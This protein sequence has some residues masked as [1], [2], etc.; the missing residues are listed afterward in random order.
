MKNL[1]L[2]IIWNNAYPFKEKILEELKTS[3]S[4]LKVT[5]ITWSKEKFNENLNRFYGQKLPKNS[6]KE[7]ACGLGPFTLVIVEDECPQY[8]DRKTTRGQFERVNIHTFDKKMLFREWTRLPSGNNCVHGTNTPE[9]TEHDL[10]LLLGVCPDDFYTNPDIVPSSLNQDIVGANGWKS[11]EQLFYVLNHTSKYVFLRNFEGIPGSFNIA[12][13]DDIDLLVEDYDNFKRIAN[14]F[15]V[16]TKKYRVQCKCLISGE[17]VQFDFRY[18]GDGYYDKCW[19]TNIMDT[20]EFNGHVF[21]PSE[22]NYRYMILY[23]AL[24]QKKTIAD[25]YIALLNKMFGDGQWDL[26]VLLK[27]LKEHEY[28]VSEPHDLSVFFNEK[29]LGKKMSLTRKMRLGFRYIRRKLFHDR[30]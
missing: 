14:A 20:R 27:F 25:N 23:H 19:E 26:A 6:F 22:E 15:D 7:K 12:G 2:Y 16:F 24:I 21:I 1:F 8:E 10:T 11:L 5:E 13:H 17:Y 28:S 30:G 4:V 9:E 29:S 3:F 18:I